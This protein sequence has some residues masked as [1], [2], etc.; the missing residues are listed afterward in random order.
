MGTVFGETIHI[1]VGKYFGSG[2]S[3]SML[4]SRCT[5]LSM[6]SLRFK[7]ERWPTGTLLGT[8]SLHHKNRGKEFFWAC[9]ASFPKKVLPAQNGKDTSKLH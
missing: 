7:K 2:H 9:S 6:L 3:P 5:L 8:L 1:H 4:N